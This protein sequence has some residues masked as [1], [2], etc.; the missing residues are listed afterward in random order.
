M[1]VRG[2]VVAAGNHSRSGLASSWAGNFAV[3]W[4]VFANAER[5]LF[6]ADERSRA[7]GAGN[8][9]AFAGGCGSVRRICQDDD[10]DVPVRESDSIDDSTRSDDAAA[11]RFAAVALFNAAVPRFIER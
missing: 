3:G 5:R 6:V 11:K 10:A 8:P 4:N 7:D 9:A 1:F 2:V